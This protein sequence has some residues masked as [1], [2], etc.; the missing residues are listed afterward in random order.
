MSQLFEKYQLTSNPNKNNCHK[1]LKKKIFFVQKLLSCYSKNSNSPQNCFSVQ[2][3]QKLVGNKIGFKNFLCIN[4]FFAILSIKFW[5]NQCLIT[6]SNKSRVCK[7]LL[8][9]VFR[10]FLE[11]LAN[12]NS[13][14]TRLVV[15]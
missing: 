10:R 14:V 3:F 11:I 6:T 7:N 9:H 15:Q 4:N 1:M 12:L 5:V 2:K 13:F 8:S